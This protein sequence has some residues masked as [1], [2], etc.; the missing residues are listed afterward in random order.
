[1]QARSSFRFSISGLQDIQ[2]S[3]ICI[4]AF[5][6]LSFACKRIRWRIMH[7]TGHPKIHLDASMTYD[8]DPDTKLDE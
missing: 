6:W 8:D 1:M 3:S 4:V 5:L 7:P 2:Q